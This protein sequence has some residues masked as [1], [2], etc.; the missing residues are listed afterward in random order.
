MPVISRT[1]RDGEKAFRCA[2]AI[3][4]ETDDID[5]DLLCAA[6]NIAHQC[7]TRR[8]V[9]ECIAFPCLYPVNLSG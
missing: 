8:R 5:A 3:S 6:T 1:M 9:A 2:I 4:F 7:H